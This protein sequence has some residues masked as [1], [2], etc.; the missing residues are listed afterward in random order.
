MCLIKY[1]VLSRTTFGL[2]GRE[3]AEG[4]WFEPTGQVKNW[5]MGTCCFLGYIVNF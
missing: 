4:Q 1:Y 3:F 5:K 2:K